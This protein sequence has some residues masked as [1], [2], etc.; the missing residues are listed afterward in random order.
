LAGISNVFAVIYLDDCLIYA[1]SAMELV[2][3]VE[4]VL[5]RFRSSHVLLKASKCI[6]GVTSVE[7]LGHLVSKDGL[8]MSPAR[9]TAFAAL[10]VPKNKQE[11]LSFLGA[12]GWFRRFI[13][14]YSMITAPLVQLTHKDAVYHWGEDEEI[15]FE[16][17]K[18]GIVNSVSLFAFDES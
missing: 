17:I 5:E 16:D 15:A 8:A 12:A 14:R 11:M 3:R 6:W 2:D 1:D 18:K 4:Q 13:P 10:P 7:Y 9:T